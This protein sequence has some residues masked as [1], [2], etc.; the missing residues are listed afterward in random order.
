M[1]K[2]GQHESVNSMRA[3]ESESFSLV[4]EQEILPQ[5]SRFIDDFFSNDE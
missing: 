1:K 4:R 3:G 2:R 5:V